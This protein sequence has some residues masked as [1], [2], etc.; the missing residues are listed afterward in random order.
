MI[1]NGFVETVLGRV[2]AWIES[3]GFLMDCLVP[4]LPEQ[5]KDVRAVGCEGGCPAVGRAAG[6]NFREVCFDDMTPLIAYE[7]FD[8]GSLTNVVLGIKGRPQLRSDVVP[9]FRLVLV[10]PCL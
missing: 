2:I 5:S 8:N 1:N 9:E 3:Q 7:A 6:P 10:F 4:C